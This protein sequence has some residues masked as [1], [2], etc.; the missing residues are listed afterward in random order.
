MSTELRSRTEEQLQKKYFQETPKGYKDIKCG[1]GFT[2]Y[3]VCKTGKANPTP[4]R[5]D[6]RLVPLDDG[7]RASRDTVDV[8]LPERLWL[9]PHWKTREQ[10]VKREGGGKT[11]LS[12]RTVYV[13]YIE[14]QQNELKIDWD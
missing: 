5:T 14:T 13:I 2:G 3:K 1:S 7:S 9:G 4:L 10:E 6:S 11:Q 8:N 12:L